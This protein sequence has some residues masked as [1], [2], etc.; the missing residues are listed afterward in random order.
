M[1]PEPYYPVNEIMPKLKTEKEAFSLIFGLQKFHQF[2]YGQKFTLLTDHQP[3]LAIL[4]PK[5]G[6]P[7]IA[8]ARMQRWALVLSAYKY[9]IAYQST[10]DYANADCLSKL[11]LQQKLKE[12]VGNP[13]D[14]SVF[15]VAQIS[16]LPPITSET[17]QSATRADPILGAVLRYTQNGW[18]T[19]FPADLKPYWERHN[20]LTVEQN[21]LMWG[22]RV[23]VP[24]NLQGRVLQE[25]HSSHPGVARMK[26]TARSYIWWPGLDAQIE[27]LASSC[28]A[29][30][31]TRNT[32]PKVPL[33]PWQWP[34]KPWSKFTS[35]LPAHF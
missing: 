29:C 15:N 2:I 9:D 21:V 7:S 33:H 8:A 13:P 22:I 14:A 1:H 11:P 34:N 16:M 6:I 28:S 10:K 12:A 31:E 4:G 32:P 30:Q 5:K 23:I 20:A 3:L 25:I 19:N 18:P 24:K 35:I 26:L 27:R 17:I